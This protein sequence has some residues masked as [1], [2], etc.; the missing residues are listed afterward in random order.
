MDFARVLEEVLRTCLKIN[1]YQLGWHLMLRKYP[2]NGESN[3]KTMVNEMETTVDFIQQGVLLK[4]SNTNNIS[5][6]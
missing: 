4:H 5:L 3:E 2:N 6:F 1:I